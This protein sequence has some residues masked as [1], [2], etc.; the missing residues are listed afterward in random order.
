MGFNNDV[1]GKRSWFLLAKNS[2]TKI[3]QTYTESIQNAI[4]EG[5]FLGITPWL[6]LLR[7]VG[8]FWA[9]KPMDFK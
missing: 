5:F 4:S 8:Y 6:I 9:K 7:F 2:W 3:H 1:V